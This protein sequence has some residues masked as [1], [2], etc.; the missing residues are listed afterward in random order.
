M[1]LQCFEQSADEHT[2]F[3][4]M[5]SNQHNMATKQINNL[6][7][8]TTANPTKIQEILHNHINHFFPQS[9]SFLQCIIQN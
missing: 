4:S 9:I 3:S 6:Q 1:H 2:M 5:L 8:N 7:K